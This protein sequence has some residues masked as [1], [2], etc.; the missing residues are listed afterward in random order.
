[1]NS[2]HSTCPHAPSG[3]NWPEGECMGLCTPVQ[4]HD[5]REEPAPW[6]HGPF[7]LRSVCGKP[8]HEYE[9]DELDRV[10]RNMD[11]SVPIPFDLCGCNEIPA[12]T[13]PM[14]GWGWVLRIFNRRVGT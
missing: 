8:L 2:K 12:P 14:E 10:L 6:P 3:C 11:P 5:D 9:P 13:S 4:L 1:M 7:D